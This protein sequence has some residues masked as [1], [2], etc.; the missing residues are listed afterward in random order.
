[1]FLISANP[2]VVKLFCFVRI[3]WLLPLES[4]FVSAGKVAA[5]EARNPN[6]ESWFVLVG[7]HCTAW[8]WKPVCVCGI[9]YSNVVAFFRKKGGAC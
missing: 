2:G 6:A 7:A 8:L 9:T 1:M 3:R 5:V 4:R